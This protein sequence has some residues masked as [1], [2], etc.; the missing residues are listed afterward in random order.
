M[1]EAAGVRVTSFS[2]HEEVEEVE[3]QYEHDESAYHKVSVIDPTATGHNMEEDEEEEE[4][5]LHVQPFRKSPVI[6]KG[7]KT[8][9]QHHY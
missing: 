2:Y 5:I 8:V 1:H 6:G 7:S 9:K 4:Q 3:E